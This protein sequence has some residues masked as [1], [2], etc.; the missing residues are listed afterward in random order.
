MG[1]LIFVGRR[2][3]DTQEQ[4]YLMREHNVPGL[5]LLESYVILVFIDLYK[6][7]ISLAGKHPLTG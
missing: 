4:E 5:I 2:I 1:K 7:I 6:R 3:I